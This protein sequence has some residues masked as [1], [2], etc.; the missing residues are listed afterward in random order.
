MNDYI[1]SM[2]EEKLTEEE[3]VEKS[4]KT[5]HSHHSHSSKHSKHSH[6]H[7]DNNKTKKKIKRFWRKNIRVISVVLSFVIIILTFLGVYLN[8]LNKYDNLLYDYNRLIDLTQNNS[9]ADIG[10]ENSIASY[11]GL[12]GKKIVCFGDSITDKGDITY[13]DVLANISGATVYNC[14]F[15]G[16]TMSDYA[17]KHDFE[18]TPFALRHLVDAIA[19]DDYFVQDAVIPCV[20][21]DFVIAVGES[22]ARSIDGNIATCSSDNPNIATVDF[23]GNN[24]TVTGVGEGDTTIHI[25]NNDYTCRVND[26]PY[27]NNRSWGDRLETLKKI[28]FSKIDYVVIAL[29]T[30][31]WDIAKTLEEYEEATE[32]VVQKINQI[33]PNIK[34]VL[35][36]PIYRCGEKNG[37]FVDSDTMTNS[38]GA[39]LYDFCRVL[40]RVAD[41]Y[42]CSYIDNYK[43]LGINKFNWNNYFSVNENG[44]PKD[45]VHPISTGKELMGKK[46][47]K[48]LI[49]GCTVNPK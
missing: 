14:G 29:G 39:V 37:Q 9:D 48:S 4:K 8:L 46:L 3:A 33:N 45:G 34:V 47:Y 11:Y 43:E 1:N 19:T 13:P 6:S 32:Y 27:K 7:S 17:E 40:E 24:I 44:L 18:F 49:E 41:K 42:N 28:D 36:S 30:N 15:N 25:N 10:D 20:S 35:M 38:N 22:E 16:T 21:S 26:K 12:K 31:D 5:E 2:D 23:S